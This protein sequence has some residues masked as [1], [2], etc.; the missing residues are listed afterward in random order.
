M[1]TYRILLDIS[2]VFSKIR[3]LFLKTYNSPFPTIFVNADNPDDAC[4]IVFNDL[5]KIIMKQNQ[6]IEMRIICRKIVKESRIDR[7]YEL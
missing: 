2:N 4:F 1:R 7:V 3:H 6:S 5:I